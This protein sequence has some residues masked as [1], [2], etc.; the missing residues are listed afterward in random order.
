MESSLPEASPAPTDTD[1]ITSK[2]AL[3]D[4]LKSK[5]GHAGN[6]ALMRDLNWPPTKYWPVRNKLIDDGRIRRGN[7][8]GGSITL[9]EAVVATPPQQ[10]VVAPPAEDK[11]RTEDSLYDP[12]SAVLKDKW[13]SDYRYRESIVEV[14]AK[15]GRRDT[16]GVWSR[17][18]ITIIGMTTF[19]YLPGRH[20]DVTTFEIKKKDAL[21]LTGVF[22]ALAHR[23]AATRAYAIFHTPDYKDEGDPREKQIVAIC[24]EAKKHG[25]GVIFI[26][27]PEKYETWDERIEAVR[28]SPNPEDLNDF[29]AVQL[30]DSTKS[31][32]VEWFK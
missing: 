2:T 11:Y 17:P 29:I 6:M 32:I 14:T 5:G 8:R 26:D 20:F 7:G 30:S 18:D 9:V 21:D 25:V 15:Q 12:I 13:T 1:L 10:Q 3:I 19:L 22:E 31:E 28:I 16:G 23:R 27:D 24:E 4:K